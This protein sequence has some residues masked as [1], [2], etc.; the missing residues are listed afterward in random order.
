M[1]I[2]WDGMWKCLALG[3]AQSQHSTNADLYHSCLHLSEKDSEM[4]GKADTMRDQ[5]D[6]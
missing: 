2:K 3:L 6:T 5:L 4:F 1:R